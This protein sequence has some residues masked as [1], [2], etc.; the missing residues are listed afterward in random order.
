MATLFAVFGL[1]LVSFFALRFATFFQTLLF[2][3]T[4]ATAIAA[5]A[6]PTTFPTIGWIAGPVAGA[7]VGLLTNLVVGHLGGHAAY[8]RFAHVNILCGVLWGIA[9]LWMPTTNAPE[10]TILGYILIVGFLVGAFSGA[11]ALPMRL[12][13]HYSSDHVVDKISQQ[14]LR[15]A[16]VAGESKALDVY[17]TEFLVCHF[18]DKLLATTIG[19]MWTIGAQ[20]G[21]MNTYHDLIELAAGYYYIAV[22]YVIITQK[23]TGLNLNAYEAIVLGPLG[24]FAA[25]LAAPIAFRIL[26]LV[27]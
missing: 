3:D 13:G 12:R 2:L 6:A 25:L 1:V 18:P 17:R 16:P 20:N 5:L 14:I 11:A 21:H 24:L 10:A 4:L 8:L 19:V 27:Q 26:H 9:A 7:A 15:R 23:K 22:G